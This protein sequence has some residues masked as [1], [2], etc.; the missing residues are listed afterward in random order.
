MDVSEHEHHHAHLVDPRL[1]HGWD[2]RN[3]SVN[4]SPWFGEEVRNGP[5]AR[6]DC[7]GH[8]SSRWRTNTGAGLAALC[9]RFSFSTGGFPTQS[10]LSS[11]PQEGRSVLIL[12][13][14]ITKVTFDR[15]CAGNVEHKASHKG[16]VSRVRSCWCAGDCRSRPISFTPET[17]L[18]RSPGI[19]QVLKQDATGEADGMAGFN[20][21]E[22][23][24]LTT[25]VHIRKLSDS[26]F[27]QNFIPLLAQVCG[28]IQWTRCEMEARSH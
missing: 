17:Q 20:V 8:H 16:W 12:L 6:T 18:T 9:R 28:L 5:V 15:A 1:T 7:L 10:A 23:F 14:Y 21:D 26:D 3:T 11:K 24:T 4:G 2:W 27:E 25:Q 13:Y 22:E 19:V